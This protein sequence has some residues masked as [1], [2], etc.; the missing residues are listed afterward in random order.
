MCTAVYSVRCRRS[1]RHS[2]LKGC[3][4]WHCYQHCWT[5]IRCKVC[6]WCSPASPSRLCRLSPGRTSALRRIEW[7][8]NKTKVSLLPAV[9]QSRERREEWQLLAG[10]PSYQFGERDGGRGEQALQQAAVGL[11]GGGRRGDHDGLEGA[12]HLSVTAPVGAAR[13]GVGGPVQ[14][15]D[16]QS[17]LSANNVVLYDFKF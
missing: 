6:W 12:L 1:V 10:G 13:A 5:V 14:R 2:V 7:D 8:E 17:Q 3:H 11:S 4:Y 16:H 15:P 9:Q